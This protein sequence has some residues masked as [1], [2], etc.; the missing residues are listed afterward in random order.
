MRW[1]G[2]AALST[3]IGAFWGVRWA[4]EDTDLR[5][6]VDTAWRMKDALQWSTLSIGAIVTLV[7]SLSMGEYKIGPLLTV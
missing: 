6:A 2:A 7:A 1:T 4:G 5:V 3:V